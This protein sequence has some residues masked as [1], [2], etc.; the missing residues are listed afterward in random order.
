[1]RKPLHQLKFGLLAAALA[2]LAIGGSAAFALPQQ[3]QAHAEGATSTTTT[4]KPADPGSQASTRLADARLKVCQNRQTAINTILTKI[5]T[6]G[7][8]QLTLFSTIADRV[9][10]FKTSKNVTVSNYD[11]LTAKLATDKTAATNDLAAMKTNS[12]LDCTSSDPKGMVTAFK[13]DLK[14]EISDL[15]TYRTDVKNLIVAVK[16]A[17]GDSQSSTDSSSTPSTKANSNATTGG[18]Q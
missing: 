9:E 6:R 3:A 17:V 1:M 14:T 12:T 4:G 10:A 7:D 2:L 16:T 13:A 15:Q 18:T 8:N 5:V 11:Q